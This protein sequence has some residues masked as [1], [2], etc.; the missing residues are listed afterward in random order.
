MENLQP[1]LVSVRFAC[2]GESF[3]LDVQEPVISSLSLRCPRCGNVQTLTEAEMAEIFE[4]A[5][6][7][8]LPSTDPI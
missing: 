6:L 1:E 2:C 5:R 3:E 4:L 7:A 8:G